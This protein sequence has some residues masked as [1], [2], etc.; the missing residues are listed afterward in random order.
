M[1]DAQR[2]FSDLSPRKQLRDVVGLVNSLQQRLAQQRP[3]TE[4]QPFPDT[5]VF[6]ILPEIRQK[7]LWMTETGLFPGR[8][9]RWTAAFDTIVRMLDSKTSPRA[10]LA[11]TNNLWHDMAERAEI[12]VREEN[13]I[14]RTD[15]R[16]IPAGNT[17]PCDIVLDNIR[18]AF[19]TGSI[20]RSAD[21]FG[22]H[23]VFLTGI[24]ASPDNPKVQ[25]T[26][27]GASKSVSIQHH[28]SLHTLIQEKK[29]AGSTIYA[30]ETVEDSGTERR[31]VRCFR[32]SDGIDPIG[33]R[34]NGIGVG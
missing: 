1:N 29:H 27:M 7:L 6:R 3:D 10:I 18:S 22:V 34:G 2:K 25:K 30:L 26:A 23:G 17:F 15:D 16:N 31:G 8:L 5:S 20:I 24:T 13:F 11:A 14:I 21:G 12:S 33:P 19:N 4:R 28:A 32:E 9:P